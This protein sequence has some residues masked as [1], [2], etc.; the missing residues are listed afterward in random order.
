MMVMST[1]QTA[2]GH[3]SVDQQRRCATS[4]LTG[5]RLFYGSFKSERKVNK[6]PYHAAPV[7]GRSHTNWSSVITNTPSL[8]LVHTLTFTLALVCPEKPYRLHSWQY[9]DSYEL[10]STLPGSDHC[11]MHSHLLRNAKPN[12]QTLR[13]I[14]IHKETRGRSAFIYW[15]KKKGRGGIR[16]VC[17]YFCFINHFW[18]LIERHISGWPWMSVQSAWM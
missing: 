10:L 16:K 15:K 3:C 13:P 4:F 11:D 12:K 17:F 6:S 7:R 18:D 2:C 14:G 1:V 5:S 8:S 9:S